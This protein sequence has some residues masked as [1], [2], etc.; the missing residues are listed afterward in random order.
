M[1]SITRRRAVSRP[2]S[3]EA[4]ILA[5]TRRILTEGASFTDL[6]VQQI[7]TA[8]GVA[9]STFYAHFRDKTDLLLRLATEMLSTSF[10]VA[11]SWEPTEGVDKAAE[12]FL[13]ILGIYREHAGVLRAI[14]EVATYDQTVRDFWSQGLARFT[15]RT[16][17]ALRV[18]QAAGRTPADIDLVSA[19]RV[20]VVGGERAIFDHITSAPPADDATFARELARTWWYGVYR[21][22]A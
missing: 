17:E 15:E 20:I 19:A 5:A 13:R 3:A 8:A 4:E 9:R 1:A 18:E 21:R 10:D 22:P 16:I 2:A 6:G 7:S 12:D 11:S 14:G